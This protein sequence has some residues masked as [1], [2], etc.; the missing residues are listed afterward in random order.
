[1]KDVNCDN[2]EQCREQQ[3]AIIERYKTNGLGKTLRTQ[4][5]D[6]ISKG[7]TKFID[8]LFPPNYG[9]IF[10]LTDDKLL[11]DANLKLKKIKKDLL[12]K[13]IVIFR[14]SKRA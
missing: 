2:L 1:M 3:L 14:T 8:E 4:N 9:T 13:Y 5:Y 7:K 11:Q 10:K 6:K 12:V